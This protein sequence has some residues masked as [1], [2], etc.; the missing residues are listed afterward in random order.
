[1]NEKISLKGRILGLAGGFGVVV[2]IPFLSSIFR[3]EKPSLALFA[4]THLLVYGLAGTLLG[5]I[6]PK[7]WRWGIWLSL[8]LWLFL[9]VSVMGAGYINV[10]LT[11][12]LPLL[13]LA[14]ISSCAGAYLGTGFK[15]RKI[16]NKK[17]L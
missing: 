12:D 4:V 17:P 14:L 13:L 3:T 9:G 1:M 2:V 5:F 11:K 10:F 16:L 8:P 15:I 6:W 7:G